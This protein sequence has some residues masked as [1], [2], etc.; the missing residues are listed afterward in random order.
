[1]NQNY[2]KRII[3]NITAIIGAF[4]LIVI[5]S[6]YP[7]VKEIQKIH[8]DINKERLILEQKIAQGMN[9]K[10]IKTELEAARKSLDQIDTMAIAEN[11]E[12]NLINKLENLAAKNSIKISINSDFKKQKVSDNFN[13]IDWQINATGSYFGLLKFWRELE[14]QTWY[15]NLDSASLSASQAD[16]TGNIAMQLSGKIFVQEKK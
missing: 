8:Q 10:E 3:I 15:Y 11:E 9:I 5:F 16:K 4:A 13:Q 7:S 2:K 6:I 1:M 14:T 12:I